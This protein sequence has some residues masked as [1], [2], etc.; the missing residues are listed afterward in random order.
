MI[1]WSGFN[2]CI[3]ATLSPV[4]FAGGPI[5]LKAAAYTAVVVG[6]MTA[7]AACAPSDRFL[8]MGGRWRRWMVRLLLPPTA[9]SLTARR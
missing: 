5:V 9:S 1:A 6:S 7:T 8:S 2:A 4:L 3:A